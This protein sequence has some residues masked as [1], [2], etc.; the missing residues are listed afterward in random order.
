MLQKFEFSRDFIANEKH[1]KYFQ[2]Y[3]YA[4]LHMSDRT[5]QS[6]LALWL[7]YVTKEATYVYIESVYI[8]SNVFKHM[9]QTKMPYEISRLY[10]IS[11]Q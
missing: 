8:K 4:K 2:S 5:L 9:T 10:E 7:F 6:Q 1:G 3:V 11:A